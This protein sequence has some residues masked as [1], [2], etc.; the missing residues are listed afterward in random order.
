M[1]LL[2][3]S[4]FATIVLSSG[5]C[6]FEE[7]DISDVKNFKMVDMDLNTM[8][9]QFDV[10]VNNPNGFNFKIK[11]G[12]V[13][14][15]IN[16]EEMGTVKLSEKIKIRKK[17]ENT[18]TIPLRI[19]LKNGALF[20]LIKISQSD[21]IVVKADGTVKGSVM[22]ISKKVPISESRTISAEQLKTILK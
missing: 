18:Y 20:K 17:R 14:I 16:D 13:D 5:G 4:I 6:E 15:K 11:G 3:W 22:G 21:N 19:E 10:D 12:D 9:V 1:R 2:G 8:N 7:P